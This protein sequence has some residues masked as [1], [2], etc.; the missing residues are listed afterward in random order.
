MALI[1]FSSSTNHCVS[2]PYWFIKDYMP[3][4]LGSY[5]KIYLYLFGMCA[6]HPDQP[7]SLEEAA[8]TLDVLHSDIIQCL[9]YWDSQGVVSFKYN[10]EEDFELSFTLDCPAPETEKAK[11]NPLPLSK[12]II[13]QTRPNYTTR[14]LMIYKTE[15]P[16]ISKL[17]LI[18]EEYLGR[19]LT[20]TDEQVLFGLYD[21]L[22][23]PLDLI[24]YLLEY[25]A[26]NNHTSIRYIE[27]VAINWIDSNITTI[28]AAKA[29]VM[30]EKKYLTILSHLGISSQ[31]V[32]KVQREYIDKWFNDYHLSMDI[33]LEGCRRTVAQTQNPNIKYLDSILSSWASY[34][35]KS[36]EDIQQLDK[37]YASNLT[38]NTLSNVSSKSKSSVD[39]NTRFTNI[40]SHNW[41][42]EEL[43]KL[44]MEYIERK[45]HGNS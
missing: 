37:A 27:K 22:H 19:L 4:A 38:K 42:F 20:P 11:E 2:V 24:E 29:R 5:V 44:E 45:L 23:M 8:K 9:K 16:N 25:C 12:T 1:K 13:S 28:E 26:S 7:L 3:K 15:N 18:A 31:N 39:K 30:K 6:A 43:E 32:T 21:W 36:L 40:Y 35:V 14:E 17:F 33:I 34:K 10:A 41:D